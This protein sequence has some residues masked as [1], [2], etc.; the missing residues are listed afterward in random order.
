MLARQSMPLPVVTVL[1]W[2]GR[3]KHHFVAVFFFSPTL[4]SYREYAIRY[5]DNIDMTTWNCLAT[6]LSIE[7]MFDD[8]VWPFYQ[9]GR[10]ACIITSIACLQFLVQ[11][12]I[13]KREKRSFIKIISQSINH[14][15]IVAFIHSFL[16][17]FISS[18][19]RS[20]LPSFLSSFI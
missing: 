16:P 7:T 17:S 6:V 20:F 1:T 9:I 15:F 10:D 12:H 18:F 13:P 14:S 2:L 19:I 11:F 4:P 8:M 3:S 5:V